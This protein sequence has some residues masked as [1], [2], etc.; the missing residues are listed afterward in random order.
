MTFSIIYEDNNLIVVNK[1]C[2]IISHDA[3]S[4]PKNIGFLLHSYFKNRGIPKPYIAVVH[5][6]DQAVSGALVIA[7]TPQAAASLSKQF[8]ERTTEKVYHALVKSVL[9][10]AKG[11]LTHYL[12]H[13]SKNNKS[14]AYDTKVPESKKCSLD[15][16]VLKKTTSYYLLEIRPR[17][18]RTHQIRCQLSA[19]GSPIKGD[20]K[21]GFDRSN[22]EGGISLHSYSISFVHPITEEKVQFTAPYSPN[23]SWTI[24]AGN[25]K[26]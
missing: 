16:E 24:V 19:T 11:S 15:Y 4:N 5:R 6:I 21:Y 9:P 23:S 1:P 20:L 17:E 2:G 12:I 7:K 13:T 10:N 22:K 14:K 8:A 26:T 25:L 3:V 18:G